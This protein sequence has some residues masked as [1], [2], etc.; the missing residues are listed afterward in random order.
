M[1]IY[2]LD[3]GFAMER[4]SVPGLLFGAVGAVGTSAEGL[5]PYSKTEK[6]K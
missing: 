3:I 6:R 2:L 4:V 1:T 5:A